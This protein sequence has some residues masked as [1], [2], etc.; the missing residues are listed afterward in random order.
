MAS[1]PNPG[2]VRA[3]S[4]SEIFASDNMSEDGDDLSDSEHSEMG[5]VDE[6]EDESGDV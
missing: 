6:N 3:G 4:L 5:S 2:P 1:H